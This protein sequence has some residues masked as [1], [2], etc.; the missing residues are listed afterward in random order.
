MTTL[1]SEIGIRLRL[2]GYEMPE[3]DHPHFRPSLM[4]A[5][6]QFV[7]HER[8]LGRVET[9]SVSAFPLEPSVIRRLVELTEPG[10]T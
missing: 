7:D 3:A 2:L 10:N 9:R 6:Q 4:N 1:Q 5:M 8:A